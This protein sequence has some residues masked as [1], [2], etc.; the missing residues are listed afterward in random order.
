VIWKGR[1]PTPRE[2]AGVL[3]LEFQVVV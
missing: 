2:G 3:A 1:A